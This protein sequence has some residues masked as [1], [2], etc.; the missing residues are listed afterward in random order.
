MVAAAAASA[1]L[2][3]YAALGLSW[4]T[5]GAGVSAFLATFG[6]LFGVYGFAVRTV[7]REGTASTPDTKHGRRRAEWALLLGGALLFRVT[8]IP[9]GSAPDRSFTDA[10]AEDLRGSGDVTYEKLVAYDDDVWRYLWDGH[11]ATS[12]RSPYALA[13]AKVEH[14]PDAAGALLGSDRWWEIYDR[15]GYPEY[16]TVYLP[17]AQSAFALAHAIRPG[18]VATWKAL[19]IGID[20]ATCA[21]LALGLAWIGRRP[22]EAIAYAWN[23]LAVK[24]LAG[25]GHVDAI[26]VLGVTTAVVLAL[27]RRRAAAGIG[28]GAA[29][30]VAIATKLA[31]VLAV[32]ALLRGV[33]RSRAAGTG[34]GVAVVTLASAIALL[35]APRVARGGPS[36]A[37]GSPLA[38]LFDAVRAF[39]SEWVFNAGPWALF[40]VA[41]GGRGARALS[42]AIVAAAALVGVRIAARREHLPAAILL[43]LGTAIVTGP[44]VMPWYTLWVL[45][46]A[47]L[48]RNRAWIAFTGLTLLSYLV[49]VDGVEHAWWRWVEYGGLAFALAVEARSRRRRDD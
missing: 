5:N 37:G 9:V 47:V 19:V 43:V 22:I 35:I 41:L 16:V 34:A 25:S 32:P 2:Y 40:E 29:T 15:I 24:E 33:G 20:L 1:A 36:G 48:C 12:G 27:G 4:N 13:P 42:L 11:V 17:G 26:V 10:I 28:I 3:V 31:P 30:G 7:F 38:S 21:V 46:C 23:P 8:M 49:Y 39:G 14:V 6:A 45:P 18:S 44:A